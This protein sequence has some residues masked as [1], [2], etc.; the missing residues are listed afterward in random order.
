MAD[1]AKAAGKDVDAVEVRGDHQT[2][3]VTAAELAVE[4]FK[5]HGAN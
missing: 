4:F 5:Q 1:R 3:V 2:M